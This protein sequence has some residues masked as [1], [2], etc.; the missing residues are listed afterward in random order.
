MVAILEKD[1]SSPLM[2]DALLS[3]ATGLGGKL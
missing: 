3:M 2:L 1:L